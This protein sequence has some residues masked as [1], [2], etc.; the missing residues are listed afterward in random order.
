MKVSADSSS[1]TPTVS[2]SATTS[3]SSSAVTTKLNETISTMDSDEQ[4]DT[5]ASTHST[6]PTTDHK[7]TSSTPS[8]EYL[9]A[10]SSYRTTTYSI[11]QTTTAQGIAEGDNITVVCKGDVGKPPAQHVFQKYHNGHILSMNFTATETSI[12]KISE[13]CSYYRTSNFTFQ[14]AAGDNNAVIRCGVNSSMTEP[15]MY[16]ETAPIEVYYEVSMPS[17]TKYPNK[18]YYV[19]GEDTSIH[20]TC[21]S[22]GNPQPDYYWYKENSDNPESTSE[23]LTITVM[24]NTNSEVYTCNVSNTFNGGTYT[25]SAKVQV[26]VKKKGKLTDA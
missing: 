20:L 19:V 3:S 22:D 18:T 23:N 26:Y 14:V 7:T 6:L 16:E 13:N 15:V 4:N 9:S 10:N 2:M 17:F 21:K 5:T 8:D 12:S 24:N 1:T 11:Q 25:R